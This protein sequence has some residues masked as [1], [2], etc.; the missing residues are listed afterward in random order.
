MKIH[1]IA[2]GERM[3]RWV[4]DG[5]LEYAMR[6]PSECSLRLVEIS[7]KRR[8]KGVD[9]ARLIR[10]EGERML[11]AI[12]RD[13]IVWALDEHGQNWSSGELA[14]HLGVCLQEGHDLVLLVGGPEGLATTCKSRAHQLWS[15]SRLTLPHFMVRVVVAEQIYRAW[16]LL[17]GHPYHRE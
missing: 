16:T 17:I 8:V 15:L 14:R 4:N 13:A 10:D 12:P 11:A 5:Y 2:I 9:L 7:A 3:P 1:L 6:L